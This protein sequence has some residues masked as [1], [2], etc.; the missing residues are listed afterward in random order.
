[1]KLLR[2]E[3]R[4]EPGRIRSGIVQGGRV[5]E[6]EGGEGVAIHEAADVRPLV[7]V[8]RSG[9]LR[10]FRRDLSAPDDDETGV[11]GFFY[12]NP[13][14]IV[15]P[16]QLINYPSFATTIR[17][18]PYFAAIIV[19]DGF[20]VSVEDADDLILGYTIVAM[21]V[22][23]DSEQSPHPTAVG[24]RYDIAAAL[25]PVITTPDDLNDFSDETEFGR[26]IILESV[27]RINSVERARGSTHSL[28]NTFAQAISS[29]SQAC[30]LREGD[31]FA[32][33]P[34]V[35]RTD[36]LILTENDDAQVTIESLGSLSIKIAPAL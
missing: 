10:V 24:R 15:G 9:S 20:R 25:G 36:S 4:S 11:P 16:S 7:P 8:T 19:A 2:F 17:L 30:P 14:A 3:L 6:T 12:T 34:I 29:A 5:Y 18:E 32:M 35:D 22:A 13:G 23:D 1:L 26:Q 33:G 31:I 27:A 21:L 28:P